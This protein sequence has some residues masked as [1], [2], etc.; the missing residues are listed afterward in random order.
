M[1]ISTTAGKYRYY[2]RGK[3]T[4]WT[5]EMWWRN[6]D[7]EGWYAEDFDLDY[8]KRHRRLFLSDRAEKRVGVAGIAALERL[9]RRALG[10]RG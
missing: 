2:L 10:E 7:G 9:S 8:D 5:L 1:R 4:A 3:G 6:P